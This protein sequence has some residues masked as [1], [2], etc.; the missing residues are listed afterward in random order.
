MDYSAYS[1]L[2]SEQKERIRAFVGFCNARDHL[3]NEIYLGSEFK[4]YPEMK[5]FYLA[6]E[7]SEIVGFLMVYADDQESAEISACVLPSRRREGI[8]SA[9]FQQAGMEL[10]KYHYSKV[11]LKTEKVFEDQQAFLSHYPVSFSHS[12]F[13]MVFDASECRPC[14]PKEGF[15]LRLAREADLPALVSISSR[16]FQNPLDVSETYI[17]QTFSG[18]NGLLFAALFQKKPVGCVSVDQSGNG[19]YLFGLCIDPEVQ[20][21]GFGRCML[22]EVLKQLRASD[23][24]EITLG[25]D[26]ENLA[27]LPLYQS[28]G[29]K[30]R[31]ETQYYEM[32]L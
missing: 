29:F 8:F 15:S 32:S 6:Q 20:H 27:A 12:E 1:V 2:S 5:V 11:L 31:T 4:A 21:Q 28:C 17:R 23:D 9:L 16:A 25:V 22:S 18:K 19:N 30:E 13:L 26:R 7:G 3:H 24:R 14:A 10:K